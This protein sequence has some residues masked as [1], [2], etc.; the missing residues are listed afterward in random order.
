MLLAKYKYILI[1]RTEKNNRQTEVKNMKK[2]RCTDGKVF[3]DQYE[4]VIHQ[5]VL[6]YKKNGGFDTV[7]VPY[8]YGQIEII[9]E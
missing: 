8:E 3:N 4:A 6:D 1:A 2:Y 5:Q 7:G 9:E